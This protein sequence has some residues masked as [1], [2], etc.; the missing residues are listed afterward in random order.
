MQLAATKIITRKTTR[1]G[2][3]AGM[4]AI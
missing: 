1:Y 4:R 3:A 2:G